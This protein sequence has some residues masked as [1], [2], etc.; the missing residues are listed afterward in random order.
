M[1]SVMMA[2]LAYFDC[3]LDAFVDLA[4]LEPCDV[5]DAAASTSFVDSLSFRWA[6]SCVEV[7]GLPSFA[8]YAAHHLTLAHRAWIASFDHCFSLVALRRSHLV[9]SDYPLAVH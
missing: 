1:S 3:S 9:E 6:C 2:R 7:A 4:V 5:V 8:Y